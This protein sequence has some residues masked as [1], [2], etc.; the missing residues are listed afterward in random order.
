MQ[1]HLLA[2]KYLCVCIFDGVCVQIC[3]GGGHIVAHNFRLVSANASLCIVLCYTGSGCVGGVIPVT[4]HV[5]VSFFSF[6]MKNL[7]V[8]TE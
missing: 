2:N 6:L 3:D 7:I 4:I 5:F 8:C 1:E